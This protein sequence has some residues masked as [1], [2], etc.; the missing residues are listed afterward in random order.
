MDWAADRYTDSV[1][2]VRYHELKTYLDAPGELCWD[3]IENLHPHRPTMSGTGWPEPVTLLTAD[4][5]ARWVAKLPD[6]QQVIC[7]I[8]AIGFVRSFWEEAVDAA[9]AEFIDTIA[10]DV[11][12]RFSTQFTEQTTDWLCVL[13]SMVS[14]A[15]EHWLIDP[16]AV[17]DVRQA[18]QLVSLVRV[19]LSN[20]WWGHWPLHTRFSLMVDALHDLT[21]AII[22]GEQPGPS[23]VQQMFDDRRTERVLEKWRARCLCALA[24]H[25]AHTVDLESADVCT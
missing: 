10:G 17:V 2:R 8:L 9:P 21:H 16:T 25:D 14:V 22:E 18:Q 15:V 4:R 23:T 20:S 1:S 12:T 19:T 5:A 13:P 3:V 11:S 24:F 6:L 7:S